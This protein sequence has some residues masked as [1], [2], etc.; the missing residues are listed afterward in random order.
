M[1]H[2]AMCLVPACVV[3]VTMS[4]HCLQQIASLKDGMKYIDLLYIFS[5]I[6]LAQVND[7]AEK[8]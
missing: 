8:H 6:C 1:L 5:C 2:N 3:C 4:A 7:R